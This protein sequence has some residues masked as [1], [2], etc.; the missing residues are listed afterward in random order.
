M[1]LKINKVFFFP[2]STKYKKETS[3]EATTTTG[4]KYDKERGNSCREI[5]QCS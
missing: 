5:V 2:D 4:R 1:I 3:Q